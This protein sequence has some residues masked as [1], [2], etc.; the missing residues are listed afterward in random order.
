MNGILQLEDGQPDPSPIAPETLSR[1][2]TGTYNQPIKIEE[3]IPLLLP[4]S[5]V[6]PYSDPDLADKIPSVK[7]PVK[8]D[9]DRI[10]KRLED[11]IQQRKCKS[12]GIYEIRNEIYLET[13][14]EMIRQISIDC[15]ERGILL[16][17]IRNE[18][19]KSIS[20]YKRLFNNSQAFA[21]RRELSAEEGVEELT[22]RKQELERRLTELK[23]R[24]IT[25]SCQMENLEANIEN[26]EV[27]NEAAK[28]EEL[29]FY[30]SLNGNVEEFLLLVKSSDPQTVKANF[31][32]NR[33]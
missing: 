20:N 23:N 7:P 29:E 6:N 15:P 18:I 24:S 5:A 27:K 14:N 28:A 11:L 13:L 2:L 19:T 10:A 8:E 9:I 16:A 33:K 32:K 25:L 3:L 12:Q 26:V 30:K 17:L 4:P 31:E 1:I 22:K 21:V